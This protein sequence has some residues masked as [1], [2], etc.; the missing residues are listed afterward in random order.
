MT[1]KIKYV[2]DVDEKISPARCRNLLGEPNAYY[3]L[4]NILKDNSEVI[5]TCPPARYMQATQLQACT[6]QLLLQHHS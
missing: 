6:L 4:C 1:G 5:P 3:S 2:S